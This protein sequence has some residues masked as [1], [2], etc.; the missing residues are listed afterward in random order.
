KRTFSD[1]PLFMKSKVLLSIYN[2]KFNEILGKDFA[3]KVKADGVTEEDLRLISEPSFLNIANLAIKYSDGIIRGSKNLK[4][5]L[6][7]LIA[8]SSKPVLDYALPEEYI[9]AYS[10]FYDKFLTDT[11]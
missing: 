7:K 1:D 6:E 10:V 8:N 5:E 2:D 4:P 11:E 3:R 9:E